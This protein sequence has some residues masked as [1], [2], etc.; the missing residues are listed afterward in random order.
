MKLETLP[1]APAKPTVSRRR[2][3]RAPVIG[4]VVIALAGGTWTAMQ[5]KNKPAPQ[6]AG[7]KGGPPKV[8]VYELASTDVAAIEAREL[9]VNLPL[10]GSL[11]PLT[12]AIVKSKVS[13]IVVGATVQEG[14]SVA[15]GQLIASLDAADQRARVA[16][17]QAAL[18]EAAAR[19]SL[20]RKN[21]ANSDA[22][23]KQNYI[24]RNSYDTTVNSVE[25]AQASVK[26]AQAQLDMARIALADTQIRAPLAGVVSKRFV[27]A[28][29]KV[30]PD[31][32]V[33]TIVN[34]QQLTLEA[35]VPAADI[36]R[37][38]VG[39]EVKFQVDGYQQRG[40][41]GKVARINPTTEA[42]SRSMLVYISV[43]NQ[44]GLL[45]GG[46]FAKGNITTEK[47]AVVPIVP[48]AALR[49]ENGVSVV[50]AIVGGKVVAQPV[51]L[52]LRNDDEGYAE[53]TDG[54]TAGAR[55]LVA[56]L[57]GVKPGNKVK[58]ADAAAPA[59]AVAK[60]G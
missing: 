58:L 52:G 27:Q 39:Q 15:A 16:Q 48:T 47:S 30:A 50:Y 20:A 10:S 12:Q 7:D 19:L 42:G 9:A 41:V 37:I 28:G 23:L 35:Q 22:L 51:K 31:M 57:D 5:S 29:E 33:A 36:P 26:A 60:K 17:M 46:M 56:K 34:L 8:D 24:S 21:N 54:L 43:S 6:A 13:G 4:L 2:R 38:K 44:D 59:A 45:R 3:W 49:Q 53:V 1:L 14:V 11:A 55:V 40:F 18:D 25:L 32:P